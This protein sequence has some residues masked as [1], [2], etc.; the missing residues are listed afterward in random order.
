MSQGGHHQFY[1]DGHGCHGATYQGIVISVAVGFL[2]DVVGILTPLLGD[3][4]ISS[5]STPSR[6]ISRV[7]WVGFPGILAGSEV[8]FCGR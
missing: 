8:A 4:V 1:G 7:F 5:I 2:I 3:G 6:A